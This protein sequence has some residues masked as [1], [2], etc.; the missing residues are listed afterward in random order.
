M[1]K[2]KFFAQPAAMTVRE[3][4]AL[5]GA[6]PAENAPLDRII[7]DIAP[8]DL[9]R[10]SDLAFVD[11]RKYADALVATGAGA[12]LMASSF[13]ASAPK[14]T[15]VLRVREPYRAFVAV[16]C[17]LYPEALRPSSLFDAQGAAAGA[18]VHPTAA[19]EEGVTI[20]PGVV[21]GPRA[22][23]G[24]GTAIAAN[25]VVG[26]DVQIG[27]N[28]SIGPGASILHALIGDGVIIHAGCRIG[29]DGFGYL[30]GMRHVK[31][32]QVGRVIIQDNVEIGANTMIDRG[33]IRDT[34]IGEGS[35]IDNLCQIG[36]NVM[37]GRHCILVAQCGLSGSVTLEDHVVLAAR[38]GIIEHIRVGE[39]AQV[40]SRSTVLRDVP[41][42]ARWGGVM[43]AKP[44]RR[45]FREMVA[46]ERLAR[47]GED[48]RND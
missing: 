37:I 15:A 12:C 31:I 43:S 16:A 34:V 4:A 44:I 35:K 21:I 40:A 9:A 11:S 38:V 48:G 13:E 29:Q 5:T 22:A 19:I 26:P 39:G 20:D 8:L 7:R 28:C 46:L 47:G 18:H 24:S 41:A 32:P 36:H 42:G 1:S 2:H 10:A 25:V 6:E 30:M 27:R 17:K 14:T 33:G 23:I 3:I 45:Y